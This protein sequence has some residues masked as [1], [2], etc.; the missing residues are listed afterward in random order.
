MSEKWTLVENIKAD[1][2]GRMFVV[3]DESQR[4]EC[5]TRNLGTPVY[6][7]DELAIIK[8]RN[9]SAPLFRDVQKVKRV[10]CMARVLKQTEQKSICSRDGGEQGVS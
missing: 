2:G 9:P 10:F 1:P 4:R 5:V 3:S 8:S 7:R 6:S